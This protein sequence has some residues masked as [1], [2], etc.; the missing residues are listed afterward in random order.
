MIHIYTLGKFSTS[1]RRGKVTVSGN[2][3]YC[4]ID[5]FIEYANAKGFFCFAYDDEVKENNA[6][7]VTTSTYTRYVNVRTALNVR[8]SPNGEIVGVL[9]NNDKVNVSETSGNWSRIGD[10]RWVCSDYLYSTQVNAQISAQVERYYSTGNYRVNA[11]VLNVRTGP[12]TNYATKR[13][14]QLTANARSQNSRLGNYYT[15]GLRRGVVVTITEI[16]NGFGKCPSSWI[17]LDYC[18]KL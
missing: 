10:S 4:P 13:Y 9:Y 12:S 18:T 17:C 16:R 2:T 14:Y 11:S 5:N 8:N 3:V 7:T 6:K 15:N 1:T